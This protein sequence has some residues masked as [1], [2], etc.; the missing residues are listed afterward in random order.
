MV[1]ETVTF[2][3]CLWLISNIQK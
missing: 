1:Q 3:L 2:P